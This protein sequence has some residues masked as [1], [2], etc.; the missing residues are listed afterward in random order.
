MET[1]S[2]RLVFK[3]PERMEGGGGATGKGFLTWS[4]RDQG[5]GDGVEVGR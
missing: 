2:W 5:I 1:F 4:E 3:V